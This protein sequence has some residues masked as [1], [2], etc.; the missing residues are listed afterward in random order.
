LSAPS[1]TSL[2]PASA[3][4][5]AAGFVLTVNDDQNSSLL[6]C[7]VVRWNGSART[8]TF[9]GVTGLNAS[10]SAADIANQGMI[11]VTVFTPGP[12]GGTSNTITF[13]IYGPPLPAERRATAQNAGQTLNSTA[14]TSAVSG[15][16][17]P[18]SLP[19]TSADSRYAA[20]VLA[21]T[22]GVTET[23]GST[24]NI[25]VRD[26][27]TGAPAGC[28]PSVT[29]A[30]VGI[31]GN[32][33]DGNSIS[34]AISADGRFVTFISSAT[35]LVNGDTN[36]LAD[37]FV[38]DTCA[39]AESGCAPSTQRI[40]VASDGT[41]ANGESTS[42]TIGANGRYVT[43]YSSATNL[44]GAVSSSASGIFLRDTCAGAGADCTPS[45]QRLQ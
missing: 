19:V 31:N 36:G 29:L 44:G 4:A 15:P 26:T 32:P 30:S 27:C 35:N 22:D 17:D 37:V 25:F 7:S 43:F 42:A 41:Q 10:I 9:V 16:S 38:R 13:T 23:A 45:T 33:A 1:I 14:A 24:E 11:P 2:S 3:D 28:T 21:S 5:G 12:G 6:P 18:L 8:T 34:P 39:G 40:S 20:S